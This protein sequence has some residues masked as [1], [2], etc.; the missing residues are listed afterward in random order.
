MTIE[1]AYK[2]GKTFLKNKL[3]NPEFEAR[4]LLQKILNINNTEFFL[5]KEVKSI[6]FLKF[7]KYLFFIHKRRK[8][9]NLYH[10]I[11]ET[12]F[13]SIPIYVNKSVLIPRNETEELVEIVLNKMNKN[14]FYH[15][16]DIGT[17][18]GC[19]SIAIAK[20]S[21]NVLIDAIDISKKALKVAKKNIKKYS[22]YNRIKLVNKDI[23][24]F[25]SD[26][27]Y[28][29]I[30]SNPPYVKREEAKELLKRNILSDPFIALNGGSDGLKF[31]YV[32][33]EV[34]IKL[35]KDTGFMIFEHGI[36]QREDIKKI[37]DKELFC[38][39][40]FNDI[41]GIDR[42]MLITRKQ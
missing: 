23:S 13:Y 17:G 26:K 1:T 10:I 35:L 42:F 15:I 12:E 31:Y 34:S 2:K 14:K 21:N 16:L 27:K 37:F 6:S 19:I 28:D 29:I 32:L 11:K 5:K 22:L 8:G 38:I 30:I 3:N 41:A 39:T 7:I 40:N 33:K 24:K 25:F 36:N 20:N 9:I 18:S 4:I